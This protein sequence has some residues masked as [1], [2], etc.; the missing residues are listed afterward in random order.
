MLCSAWGAL[1]PKEIVGGHRV[2]VCMSVSIY[3][4]E[5]NWR[6]PY[7][8][9]PMREKHCPALFIQLLLSM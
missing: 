6:D 3:N 4:H 8:E 7:G 5:Q 1:K 9:T 2:V